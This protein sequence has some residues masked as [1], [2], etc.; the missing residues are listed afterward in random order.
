LKECEIL[1][2]GGGRSVKIR[3]YTQNLIPGRAECGILIDDSVPQRFQQ[4][5]GLHLKGTEEPGQVYRIQIRVMMKLVGPDKKHLA[6]GK[7]MNPM[8][9]MDLAMRLEV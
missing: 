4:R 5:G 3:P 7:G 8:I 6:G 1:R 9:H 2:L